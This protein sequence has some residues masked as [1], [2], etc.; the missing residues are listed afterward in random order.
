LGSVLT[1]ERP[2]RGI[3][4]HTLVVNGEYVI[5][6]DMLITKGKSR[7]ESEARAYA[8]LIDSP[9]PVPRV[10]AL[11][12]SKLIVPYDYLVT[13]KLPGRPVA[14]AWASL[15]D[16]QRVKVAY[17]SGKYLAV[18]HNHT[19]EG[20]GKLRDLEKGGFSIWFDY[21]HDYF[22]RY[23]SQALDLGALNI[24]TVERVDAALARHRSLLESVKVAS[25]V[26]SDYHLEN[27]LTADGQ[28]SGIIDFEWAFA[29]D[30]VADFV[31]EDK[32]DE[33]CPGSVPFV[34]RGYLSERELDPDHE[35][36]VAL[37][38]MVGHVESIVDTMRAGDSNGCERFRRMMLDELGRL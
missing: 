31:V 4:N 1:V 34:Y 16:Q 25:L 6:F 14:D 8:A 37:Y 9:V 17:W 22:Q 24:A 27:V 33:M 29:G 5:R 32:W 36:K 12:H 13:T 7:F 18:I 19:F 26:H 2:E 30:P 20:F 23:A 21:M 35:A 38:K 10:S 11:D 28:I 3:I 15:T